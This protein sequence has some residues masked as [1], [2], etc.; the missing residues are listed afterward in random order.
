MKIN[1]KACRQRAGRAEVSGGADGLKQRLGI[2]CDRGFLQLLEQDS[3]LRRN[4]HCV[5]HPV[6]KLSRKKVLALRS[7]L[8]GS[9]IQLPHDKGDVHESLVCPYL[10]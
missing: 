3:G 2:A 4:C 10:V 7:P 1:G 6:M 9:L 8:R 5:P